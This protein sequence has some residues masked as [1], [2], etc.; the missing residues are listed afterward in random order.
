MPRRFLCAAIILMSLAAVAAAQRRGGGAS[1]DA[2]SFRFLGPV[3]GNRVAS[4]AGVPGDPS[5]YYAGAASGGVW[6]STDGG[7]H[8]NAVSDSMPVAAIGALAVAPS[9][10]SIVWAGTGEAWAIR[11]SDVIGDGIYKSV[12]AGKTWV[13]SGLDETGRIG[14][15]IVHPTNPDIVFACAIG[16]ITGPQQERGVFRTT[17]GGQHW[18]RVLFVDE[19]TGC[20]GLS[21]D[22]KNP[23]TLFA[24]TWQVEMHPWAMSSGGAGSA[25]YVSHDGGSTWTKIEAPGLPGSPLGKI[26]VAVAPA[27]S[28]RVYVL[29]QT[30]DQG[31]VWRSDDGGSSW[32]VVNWS[33]ELIGRAGYYIHLAVSPANEDEILISNSSFFQSV[34]GGQTF[35]SVNWGGDNHDIWWDPKDPDRFAITHDAGITLTTQH[36]RSTQRVQLPIGQM[37]H[38]AVD[39]QLPYYVY[40]NM[41][42]DGTMRGPA[43]AAENAGAGYNGSGNAWDH[44]LGGCESG[45]TIP[46]PS[47]PN[48][49][50]ATCYGNKVTR[51]DHRTKI[52]RSVAPWMITLD[53]PPQDSKYRCH[54]TAPIAIDPF[55]AKNVYYGCNVIFR[56]T[57]GG[58]NWQVISPDLSTQDPKYIVSS[59]GIVG[60]NLGQFAPEVIFAIAPSEIERG[61]IWAGT[62]DGKVWYTKDG[63]AKWNDVSKN[64]TGM[65]AWGVVSKIEPSH[66]NGATAYA[67]VDAHLMDSREP[68]IFKT[69]D[70]GA[71]WKRVSGDLPNRHPLS[72][73]K[74]VAENPNKQGQLFAGTGH[75]FFYSNDD[76][77]HWIE[78]S[79]GLPKAPVSWVV[80]QKQ[81]HDVVVSTYGRGIY[82]LDDITP[83]EQRTPATTDAAMHL[84]APR[85]AYRW[86]QRGRAYVSFSLKAAPR[87][88]AEAQI[89]DGDGKVVRALRADARAGLNRIAWDLRYDPPRLIEMRTTPPENPHIWEE[90]RF[91]GKDTRPVTHWGLEPAQVGPIVV[92]GKYTV[93]LTV[94]GQ[95]ATQPIE[96]LK[97]P[98]VPTS[99]ADLDLSVKLQLRLRDDISAAADMVNSI[100]VMRKQLEDVTKAFRGDHTKDGMLRQIAD[101]DKKLFDV[102]SKLLEPAQ[103]TSDDKYF[104]QAYRVYMN[105]IWLNGEV[106]PGA[107]DVLGGAD[108]APTDTSVNVMETI[109]K[110]LNAAKAEYKNVMERDVPAFNRSVSG[111]MTPLVGR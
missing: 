18:D 109:E 62:N 86:T 77:G 48:I 22:V 74:A 32:R 44:G 59:G 39:D 11:D 8:W 33:R 45:F 2:L 41:Q 101:I 50:W 108:F 17:D 79:A 52:A 6:K 75:G 28:N 63:G 5:I 103:M 29:I 42:D 60:D 55:D 19:N 47:D 12:D 94:D 91:R 104:Q 35:R 61:L 3:V 67:A 76:G 15:I 110:D 73:V 98:K 13:H 34:D 25:L 111:S 36:G 40:G 56:T 80:V 21:M 84:F 87:G 107:G 82:V 38:V 7:L 14:R 30:K 23:R 105:L 66:F 1:P 49:V 51:Y 71:T 83:L 58:Q 96:I 97:D 69:T 92:P 81:F 70:Y 64:I 68:Y 65:P 16:R 26:D 100:E 20:S 93:K 85:S 4:I 89:L 90:P 95:S 72:Y 102:E 27:D 57:T 53:S 46:D 9:D 78:M 43:W 88:Q 31:S 24:G 54:W 106:G 10:P 37:Y 99:I